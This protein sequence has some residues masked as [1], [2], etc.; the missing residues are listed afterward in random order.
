MNNHNYKLL[1]DDEHVS[2]SEFSLAITLICLGFKLDALNRNDQT[3][4]KIEFTFSKTGALEAAITRYW[5]GDLLI[6]PKT[7]WNV[8]RELKSRMRSAGAYAT[9]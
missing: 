1:K 9:D 6:E 8:S 4:R 3:Y 2:F 7:F 5:N